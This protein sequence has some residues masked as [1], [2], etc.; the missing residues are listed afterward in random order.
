[1]ISILENN[2]LVII[3]SLAFSIVFLEKNHK[4]IG[5]INLLVYVVLLFY[6]IAGSYLDNIIINCIRQ[7]GYA[8][9]SLNLL[10]FFSRIIKAD[11][12]SYILSFVTF[13]SV[14]LLVHGY[15]FDLLIVSRRSELIAKNYEL[16]ID[17]IFY[18]V[19]C[20]IGSIIIVINNRETITS[21]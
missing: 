18:L 9:F 6:I 20:L 17:I 14:L 8:L 21:K 5:Y 15:I 12:F 11:Y 2:I 3:I 1:M 10:Y 13:M 19:I 7:L 4:I 16:M